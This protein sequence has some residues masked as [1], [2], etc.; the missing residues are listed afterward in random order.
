[1]TLP[2]GTRR[3][4]AHFAR[5][6][7]DL[8]EDEPLIVERLLEDGDGAD[9]R[10][11]TS[12]LSEPQLAAWF[13]ERAARRLSVRSAAFWGMVLDRPPARRAPTREQLW[14]L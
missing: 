14:P 5:S 4:F 8:S 10:W 13:E 9:L 7:P 3:L 12:A 2:A 6:R 11:L 1:M